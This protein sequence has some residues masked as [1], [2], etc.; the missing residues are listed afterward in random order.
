M[1]YP[2]NYTTDEAGVGT[3]APSGTEG[4][5][6]ARQETLLDL[7]GIA[8]YWIA[9][10][11]TWDLDAPDITAWIGEVTRR[12]GL[13]T[14][15]VRSGTAPVFGTTAEFRL[16]EADLGPF[17]GDGA[18]AIAGAWFASCERSVLFAV[19]AERGSPDNVEQR[20]GDVLAS[21]RCEAPP[22][23]A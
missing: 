8:L 5:F 21:F 22:R 20:M 11:V 3:A 7:D 2:G 17:R 23:G 18:Y 9:D 19:F 10:T 14:T 15:T 16:L 13:E 1:E 4:V 6:T 12:E